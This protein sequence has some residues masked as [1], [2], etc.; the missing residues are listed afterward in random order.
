MALTTGV[1]ENFEAFIAAQVSA[2][3]ALAGITV[4]V[5]PEKNIVAEINVN[6]AKISTLIVPYVYQA[7][8]DDSG[9]EGTFFDETLFTVSVFQNPKL[10]TAGLSARSI[11]EIITATIKG[12]SGWPRSISLRSPAI[13]HIY[14]EELNV[15]QVNGRVALDGTILPKLP[16]VTGAAAGG[17]V[18]LA[19][20]QPGA[21][22]FYRTD[23]IEPTTSDTLYTAP[24]ASAG[25]TVTARAWLAGF[26]ASDYFNLNT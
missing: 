20:A 1:L 16:A 2:V 14:D 23:G 24:F 25:Q 11:A 15:Y 22:V 26:L 19:N 9:V 4:L 3:G 7:S 13:Q 12:N 8:D 18:T 17:H 6:I 21:A 5:A 10:V